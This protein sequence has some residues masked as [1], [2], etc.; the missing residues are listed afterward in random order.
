MEIRYNPVKIVVETCVQLRLHQAK[1]LLHRFCA[2][3]PNPA[4]QGAILIDQNFNRSVWV[5]G[6]TLGS[7]L[8][9]CR[10]LMTAFDELYRTVDTRWDVLLSI[11]HNPLI[12]DRLLY[13]QNRT[14]NLA[15]ISCPSRWQRTCRLDVV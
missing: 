2:A 3:P 14:E 12:L 1:W 6:L 11:L 8:S 15:S 5:A 7:G 13:L 4:R 10:Q 9:F